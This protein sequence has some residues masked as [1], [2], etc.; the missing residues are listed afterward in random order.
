MKRLDEILRQ[1]QPLDRPGAGTEA[2]Q[3]ETAAEKEDVCPLCDGAGFVR[4]ALPVDHPE[5]GK[6]FPCECALRE[7]EEHKFERLQRYSNLGP[8]VRLTFGNLSVRGRSSNPRDQ[9]RFQRC[10]EESRAFAENPSGWLVLAGPERLRQDTRGRRNHEPMPGAGTPALFGTV[11]DLLDRLRAAYHP[12]R[13]SARRDV[14]AGRNV[15]CSSSMTWAASADAVGAGEA[16]ADHQPSLQRRLPTVI[17]NCGPVHKLERAAAD[18]A[19]G[20][21]TQPRVRAGAGSGRRGRRK[22]DVSTSCG[23]AT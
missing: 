6:A 11:P 18:P 5:F 22:L 15:A 12:E 16:I 1:T 19:N 9:E 3:V 14:R 7:L 13:R 23:S 8:L 2:E 21:I 10:V 20:P 17:T 4:R